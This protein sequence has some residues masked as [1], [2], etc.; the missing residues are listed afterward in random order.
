MDAFSSSDEAFTAD[1]LFTAYADGGA[2]KI[3]A[4]VQVRG[5]GISYGKRESTCMLHN[6]A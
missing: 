3:R 2:D 5:W 1:A 4:L 6:A